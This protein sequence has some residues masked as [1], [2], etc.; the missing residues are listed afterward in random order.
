M[1]RPIVSWLGRILKRLGRLLTDA[2]HALELWAWR[3]RPGET[4]T[5]TVTYVNAKGEPSEPAPEPF[6]T[7]N[8]ERAE[9]PERRVIYRERKP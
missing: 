5:Y 3:P 8:L 7:I 2:G 1:I 4:F 6:A 9:G